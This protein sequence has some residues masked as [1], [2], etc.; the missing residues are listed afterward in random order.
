MGWIHVATSLLNPFGCILNKYYDNR[1]IVKD[2]FVSILHV[3]SIYIYLILDDDDD[4]DI[5]FLIDRNLQVKIK[6]HF[7]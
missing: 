5:N 2:D 1:F 4:F 7:M 6:R 3:I